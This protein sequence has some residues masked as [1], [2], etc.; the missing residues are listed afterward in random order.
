MKTLFSI[1][2]LPLPALFMSAL[3]GR[4][5]TVD[6]IAVSVGT[7]VIA[8]S[9]VFLDIR[10]VAFLEKG[11]IVISAET[12]RKAAERL[13]DQVLILREANES[14]LT[15]PTSDLA[16]PLLAQVKAGHGSAYEAELKRCGVTES[17]VVAQ[18]LAGLKT[19]AFT[20]LRF[21]PAVQVTEAELREYYEK[22]KTQRPG[23]EAPPFESSRAEIEQLFVGQR[24][25]DALDQWLSSARAAA[26][27][28]YRER[29][30]Q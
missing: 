22:L 13:V 8:E 15:L 5:E 24:V 16:A 14:H 19:S 1:L 21:R 6:R 4:A 17:D 18:L 23:A 11:P 12:K 26:H 29:V 28:D 7:Q 20:D 27:P 30:F 3:P 10:V 2:V 25:L 9:S